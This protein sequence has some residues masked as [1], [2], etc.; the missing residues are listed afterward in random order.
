MS[1]G[2]WFS[3]ALTAGAARGRVRRARFG[4]WAAVVAALGAAL[5]LANPVGA[6]T[7]TGTTGLLQV[8][9]ADSL[10]QGEWRLAAGF[11]SS[12]FM[13]SV[14]YGALAGLEIGVTT[15]A[16]GG[17]T[18]RLK[19]TVA[20]ETAAAPGL[21][22]GVEGNS[23]YAV[24]SRRLNTPGLRVHVGVGS[25]RFGPVVAGIE[26]RLRSVAVATADAR[27][28]AP[29][30]SLLVDYDGEAAGVGARLDFASG[31]TLSAGV[32][33]GDGVLGSAAYGMR[34]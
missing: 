5:V 2:R 21:A 33:L 27:A 20:A 18:P 13:P 4:V 11:D 8:P 30:V 16:D 19:Y 14:S 28:S 15:H 25:S 24:A 22:V 9:T 1:I 10:A 34:F 29:A 6:A 32:R 31:L 12:G 23:W 3:A 26:A 7:I 17:I